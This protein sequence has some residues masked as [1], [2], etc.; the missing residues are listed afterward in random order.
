MRRPSCQ[1]QDIPLVKTHFCSLEVSSKIKLSGRFK[2]L[3]LGKR[4][5]YSRHRNKTY[6]RT[7]GA[8]CVTSANLS[9]PLLVPPAAEAIRPHVRFP[10]SNVR[11]RRV[12]LQFQ[13]VL[14]LCPSCQF[15]SIIHASCTGLATPELVFF[16]AYLHRLQ[17]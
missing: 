12:Q 3:L 5:L 13:D 14:G 9:S 11:R 10:P 17:Y 6:P 7:P 16:H 8:I 1:S 2:V 4:E 15:V